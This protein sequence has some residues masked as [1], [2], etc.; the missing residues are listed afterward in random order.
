MVPEDTEGETRGG[1]SVGVPVPPL[2]SPSSSPFDDLSSSESSSPVR[3]GGVGVLGTAP[4]S[5]IVW[6]RVSTIQKG[7]SLL[8]RKRPVE[9]VPCKA[10]VGPDVRTREPGRRPEPRPPNTL[11]PSPISSQLTQPPITCASH[12]LIP[13]T[14]R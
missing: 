3:G 11:Q 8:P 5:L 9:R 7:P 6:G 12:I 1:D 13:P 4:G 10:V 14:R 2:C